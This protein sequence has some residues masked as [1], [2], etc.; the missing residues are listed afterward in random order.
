MPAS[1]LTA[2]LRGNPQRFKRSVE[3]SIDL[4]PT[5]NAFI[6]SFNGKRLMYGAVSMG[7]G[8]TKD[9]SCDFPADQFDLYEINYRLTYGCGCQK[10]INSGFK[11]D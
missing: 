10:T 6:E 2:D 4:K 5:Q 3:F 9:R 7:E 8:D 1:G 11:S